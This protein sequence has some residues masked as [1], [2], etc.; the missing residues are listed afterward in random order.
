MCT[1]LFQ[2]VRSKYCHQQI[3]ACCL[4]FYK[5]EIE[6]RRFNRSGHELKNKHYFAYKTSNFHLS[7]QEAN[8]LPC[9]CCILEHLVKLSH[10]EKPVAYHSISLIRHRTQNASSTGISINLSPREQRCWIT[11]QREI[12][13]RG[14]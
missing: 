2:H 3:Y 8:N 4:F 7:I 10:S 12:Q 11:I 5:K 13:P 1:I 9:T 6:I 14:Y